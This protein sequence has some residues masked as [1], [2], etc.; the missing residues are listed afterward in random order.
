MN[1]SPFLFVCGAVVIGSFGC[2]GDAS[3]TPEGNKAIEWKQTKQPDGGHVL[4]L[5]I[6]GDETILAGTNFGL[7]YS[8]NSGESW[9]KSNL[10]N[11]AVNALHI[12]L[13]GNVLAGT[14]N[15]I[16]GSVDGGRS[17]LEMSTGLGETRV[18][19]F[20]EQKADRIF[21]GTDAGLFV[22]TNRG[23]SWSISSF[24][25]TLISA[26]C[27]DNDDSLLIGVRSGA[28][29]AGIFR[30]SDGSA[31][32]RQLLSLQTAI[33]TLVVRTDGQI[34]AG[35]V[36]NEFFPGSQI[37]FYSQDNGA[38]WRGTPAFSIGLNAKAV[39]SL[40]VIAGNRI[41]AGTGGGDVFGEG[42]DGLFVSD[43]FGA[44]WNTLGLS[45]NVV[46][47]LTEG[48]DAT[49]LAGTSSG[50]LRSSTE[51][52]TW[53]FRNQGLSFPWDSVEIHFLARSPDGTILAGTAH[54]G[55]L[56]STDQGMTWT[57]AGLSNV[58]DILSFA[59][60]PTGDLLAGTANNI[61]R[62]TDNGKNWK[63]T[64]SFSPETRAM[65]LSR[66]GSLIA[67]TAFGVLKSTDQGQTW[68]SFI[69]LRKDGDLQNDAVTALVL[70]TDGIILAGTRRNGVFRS[71]DDGDSWTSTNVGLGD[72]LI[73]VLV[74]D[75]LGTIWAGTSRGV[76]KSTNKADSW[77]QS[78]LVDILV[79]CLVVNSGMV[80]FAA[81]PEGVFFSED[82]GVMWQ[83]A[84]VGLGDNAV[85][86]LLGTSSGYFLAGTKAKGVFR[87]INQIE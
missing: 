22:S 65:I 40:L 83:E 27:I 51:G 63:S 75:D 38:S 61:Y 74:A 14:V 2:S 56:L 52:Q 70:E 37:F 76:F 39:R 42:G 33:L 78:G 24:E 10:P 12:S 80:L 87:T 35:S 25:D 29:E 7:F 62:S 46:F 3:V 86:A 26:I 53:S 64:R 48:P 30:R 72:S 85:K 55:L 17:W 4:S 32:W 69:E 11:I 47:S 21:A 79:N 82:G 19:A 44:T 28:G 50:F 36:A 43:D 6:N 41:L 1:I 45:S 59:M 13:S 58:V 9:N 31:Q 5:V 34:L 84:N 68:T 18:N 15:G 57:Q 71:K 54:D 66:N 60:G 20:A 67:G 8:D 81:T 23:Q 49:V 77:E 73:Q 16:L